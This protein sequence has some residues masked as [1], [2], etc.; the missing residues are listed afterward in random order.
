MA[1]IYTFGIAFNR[2]FLVYLALLSLSAFT[3]VRSLVALDARDIA[4][5]FGE[6]TPARGVALFLWIIGGMLGLIELAQVVPTIVTG[7]LPE[8]ITKTG[9][10]TGVVYIADLGLVVPLMLLVGRWL[11]SRR[12]WGFGPQRSYSSRA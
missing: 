7:E 12:P 3:I 8:L 11:R 4:G 9:H 1:P 2:L 6:R 5:R 10:L